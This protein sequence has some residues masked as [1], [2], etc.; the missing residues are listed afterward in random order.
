MSGT[1]TTSSILSPVSFL[2]I[3][4]SY[5]PVMGGSEIEAQRVCS[6]M[7]QRG[8]RALV[9][10]AGGPP[11][12]PV[13]D[14]I[15]PAGVPVRI[16][17]RCAKGR[18]KDAVFACQVAR[19]I[20]RERHNYEIVYFLMQGLHLA[21]GLPVARAAGKP[22]VMKVGGSGV[23][24]LMRK[25]LAGRVEL[26]WLRKWASRLMVL[27][28]GMMEE[29]IS[30][31]FPSEL[32]TW[33]P[34]PVDTSEF[35]PGPPTEVADLRRRYGIPGDA[36]VAIYVGRL[37]PEKG[38]PSMLRGFAL[39]AQSMPQALLILLGDG[40]MRQSL[41]MMASELGL[42]PHQVRFAGRV[43][44]SEVAYWLRASDVF[45]LVSPSEGFSCAL[46]EAMSSGLPA[47]VSD[48]P[49]N[50]QLIDPGIH[51]FTVPFGDESAAAEALRATFTNHTLRIRMGQAAR[52]RMIDNCSTQKVIDRYEE[53]FAEVLSSSRTR[54]A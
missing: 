2:L 9:L 52:Q 21:V 10:C 11:M 17:T 30:D 45:V 6:A 28:Q 35:R 46:V 8:H 12:P 19:M 47:V 20:W 51:G 53:L 7:I 43:D 26:H 34:N 48:I 54:G 5:P 49:A 41:E 14:W 37:S 16:L 27:N 23:I 25:S 42:A 36:H 39:A 24:P 31:G 38:L 50:V 15:D 4:D 13:R 1:V 3:C 22:I 40:P 44:A 29:A 18:W 33:M 32:M